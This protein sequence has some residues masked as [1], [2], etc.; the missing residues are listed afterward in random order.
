MHTKLALKKIGVLIALLLVLLMG[1]TIE[2]PS[3]QAMGSAWEM[4]VYDPAAAMVM[5]YDLNGGIGGKTIQGITP[6]TNMMDVKLSND[7]QKLAFIRSDMP[8]RVFL[9]KFD[10]GTCCVEIQYPAVV[11]S[12]TIETFFMAGFDP[13]SNLLALSF[14]YNVDFPNPNYQP[15]LMTVDAT[16]GQI[17]NQFY[18]FAGLGGGSFPIMMEEWRADGVYFLPSC[19]A[20][21]P[22]PEGLLWVWNPTGGTLSQSGEFVSLFYGERLY[23]T[24]ELLYTYPDPGLPLAPQD[25]PYAY[26]NAVRYY[27]SWQIPDS[28]FNFEGKVLAMVSEGQLLYHNPSE[29]NLPLAEW[30]ADG[31]AFLLYGIPGELS[32]LVFRDGR[33]ELFSL[34]PNMQFLAGTPEGWLMYRDDGGSGQ[35]FHYT[36]N[37]GLNSTNFGAY[38]PGFVL[39]DPARTMGLSVSG[40]FSQNIS[41]AASTPISMPSPPPG[42]GPTSLTTPTPV[43]CGNNLPPRLKVGGNGRVT[44]GDPNNF[45]DGPSLSAKDIGDIPGGASFSILAGP[46][47][48]N[49]MA[50]WQVN[51]NGQVGWTSEGSG[52]TYWLEPLPN[53]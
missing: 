47:C 37:G 2:Q 8:N 42:P 36:Y 7:G 3:S 19:Y 31:Q 28:Y 49:N 17:V 51:Y 25:G 18:D 23:N 35:L 13:N 33:E 38:S 1:G 10:S 20:C 53:G 43:N 15:G 14:I 12:G 44:P 29:L 6:G 32:S 4:W 22:A 50:W 24:G 52:N 46:V 39:F 41:T 16:T 48:A 9:G 21:E 26:P 45:R 11:A 40:P 34:P 30:V 27:E 5:A